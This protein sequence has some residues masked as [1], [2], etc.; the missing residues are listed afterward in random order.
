[1]CVIKARYVCVIAELYV[2]LFDAVSGNG[3]PFSSANVSCHILPAH[4]SIM[5]FLLNRRC[6]LRSSDSPCCFTT[7]AAV[8][9]Q[10]F[11]VAASLRHQ[12]KTFLYPA[13]RVGLGRLAAWHLPG[14]PVGPVSSWAATSNVEVG[15]TT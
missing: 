11:P 10:S 15:Q 1:M 14:G 6:R 3:L 5:H 12:L 2:C 4:S 8:G 9:S 7:P 13:I